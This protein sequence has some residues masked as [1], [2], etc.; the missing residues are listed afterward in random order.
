MSMKQPVDN[1]AFS[2]E[3]KTYYI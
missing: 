3:I 2:Q 1:F